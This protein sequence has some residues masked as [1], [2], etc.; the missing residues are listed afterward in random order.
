[1]LKASNI[2][3]E[4]AERAGAVNCGGIGA[5]HL[6]VQREFENKK[7]VGEALAQIE[8]QPQQ[9]RKKYRVIILRKNISVQKGEKAL[10]DEV[11]YFFHITNRKD[12]PEKIVGLANGRCDQENVIE[13]LKNGVN[14]MRMPVADLVS[15]WAYMVTLAEDGNITTNVLEKQ[16]DWLK[17]KRAR[18][19]EPGGGS[20]A[21]L[22]SVLG[23]D[24]LARLDLI[25]RFQLSGVIRV[26]GESRTA[27]E[28]GRKLYA[29]TRHAKSNDSDRVVK[30]LK[31]F[32]LRFS[33]CTNVSSSNA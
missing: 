14:A 23:A 8:Y 9:C 25:D 11:R 2:H 13:Q 30:Y 17:Q 12:R 15:N 26:C 29:A 21:M 18:E 1:M 3:Y 28:A 24:R 27:A 4:M 31:Q 32:E 10:F 5:M 19:E 22:R 20:D 16:I 7:L 33:D 6:M